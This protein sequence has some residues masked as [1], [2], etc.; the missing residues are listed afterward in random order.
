MTELDS[1]KA[2][3]R[4]DQLKKARRKRK[5]W[6]K[7]ISMF[8]GLFL[9]WITACI[10]VKTF[11][12]KKLMSYCFTEYKPDYKKIQAEHNL[13]TDWTTWYKT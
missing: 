9:G 2:L 8:A 10:V 1:V 11:K 7:I 5:T 4:Y 3:E 6:I 13:P 12:T